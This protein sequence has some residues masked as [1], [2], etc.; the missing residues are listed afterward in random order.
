MLL[1][2]PSLGEGYSFCEVAPG[3]GRLFSYVQIVR[4]HVRTGTIVAGGLRTVC[5]LMHLHCVMRSADC[6]SL[7]VCQ[8]RVEKSEPL[9]NVQV[10]LTNLFPLSSVP[11]A[12]R[13]PQHHDVRVTLSSERPVPHARFV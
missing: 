1:S 9:R 2:L 5:G 11:S 6:R 8:P 10:H 7:D 12:S 3:I 13:S 4:V